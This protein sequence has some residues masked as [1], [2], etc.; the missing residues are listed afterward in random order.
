MKTNKDFWSYLAQF[1][2]ELEKLQKN[3][4]RENQN[5]F[6]IQQRFSE[7]HFV[8]EI[9]WKNSVEPSRLQMAI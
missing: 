6:Y 2:L 8:Y 1:F 9:M 3:I 5:T 7:N 4:Y